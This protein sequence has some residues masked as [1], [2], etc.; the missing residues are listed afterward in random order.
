MC[1]YTFSLFTVESSELKA[2]DKESFVNSLCVGESVCTGICLVIVVDFTAL[3]L[4]CTQMFCL[5]LFVPLLCLCVC[6]RMLGAIIFAIK[7]NKQTK[8]R[9]IKN[10]EHRKTL[11]Q[12][13]FFGQ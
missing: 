12:T 10:T 9:K 5:H 7:T 6:F 13:C 3:L 4:N 2:V 8:K 11:T 1:I